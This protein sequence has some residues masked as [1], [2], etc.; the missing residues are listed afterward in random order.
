MSKNV[1]MLKKMKQ[2]NICNRGRIMGIM[3]NSFS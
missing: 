2:H 1:T 3:F